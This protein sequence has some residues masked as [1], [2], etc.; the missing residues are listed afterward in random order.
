MN[1]PQGG[2]GKIINI[3]LSDVR[4]PAVLASF[5]L[6]F[7]VVYLKQNINLD[8][9]LYMRAANMILE[10]DWKGACDLYNWLLY[11]SLIALVSKISGVGLQA[12]AYFL[13]ACFAGLLSYVFI[14]LVQE[15]G[16]SRKTIVAAAL[17]IVFY[18]ELNEYSYKVIR[19]NG[20]WPFYL[21]SLLYFIRFLKAPRWR[22]AVFWNISMIVAAL[23]R[24]EGVVFIALLP[25]VLFWQ[26]D[27]SFL[28][29]SKSFL[30]AHSVNLAVLS[31]FLV[32]QAIR[33]NSLAL[34]P[35]R[36]FDPLL[37]LNA[38]WEEITVGLA[39]KS[40]ILATTL[41]NQYS[42]NYATLIVLL[43][44]IIIFL[45]KL[46]EVI[47]PLLFCLLLIV[48]FVKFAELKSKG[49][50]VILWAGVINVLILFTFLLPQ[51]FLQ[52]RYVVALALTLLL[53]LPF[54]L[55][56]LYE[57]WQMIPSKI[58]GQAWLCY[59]LAL[60]LFVNSGEALVAIPGSSNKKYIKDSGRW[61]KENV[62]VTANI[63]SNNI[64]ILFYSGHIYGHRGAPVLTVR[65]DVTHEWLEQGQV[66]KYDYLAL[67]VRH[68]KSPDQEEIVAALGRQP[69][70][71]FENKRKDKVLVFE[72]K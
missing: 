53:L 26:R 1:A 30:M 38:L 32:F 3:L 10:G 34:R 23:F 28:K 70:R 5:I 54:V 67:R 21:L 8:G 36:L 40:D 49:A 14:S 39:G 29:R 9:I 12:A 27:W 17:V 42:E 24:V 19:G 66:G 59:F 2:K 65:E 4:V 57:K 64:K 47:T 11:P 62:P 33:I 50:T 35:G 37:S 68:G 71:M 61:I 51:F 56:F 72:G 20:Y 43:I 45:G 25:C 63:Y 6:S 41:L 58:S 7:W 55:V 31:A 18:P 22:Y 69:I 15:I 46:I 16:G 52:G 44:P 13:N 48:P 60:L